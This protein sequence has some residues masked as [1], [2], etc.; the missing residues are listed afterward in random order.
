MSAD[1]GRSASATPQYDFVVLGAGPAGQKA[2]IQAAKEGQR[3]LLVDRAASAGGECV[4]RG[5]IPSKT[6]RESALR[7][8]DRLGSASGAVSGIPG[9]GPLGLL[10]PRAPVEPLMQRLHAVLTAHES[11]IGRQLDRNG[12]E[13]RRGRARF[14][15]PHTIEITSV[16]GTRRD[17]RGRFVVVA[18]GSRP[19][20]PPEIEVDHEHVLDSD[21]ILSLIYLPCSLIVLG[22]GVIACEFATIFQALGVQV[23]LVDRAERPLAFLDREL[24]DLFVR[25]F[26]RMGGR[27]VAATAAASA[28]H[29]GIANVHVS[30]AGGGML[31]AEKVLVALGRTASIADLGLATAGLGPNARGFL[32]VDAN[33]RTAVPHVYAAGDVIGPPALAASSMEQGRRAV[34]HALGLELGPPHDT[35]PSGIYTIPELASVGIGEAEAQ[36]RGLAIVVGRARFEELARGQING[37]T[38]GLLKLVCDARGERLLGAQILG[39]GAT[40]LIHLAQMAMVGELPVS[41]FVE[42][43]FNFPT[44]AEAYRVAALDVA[45]Q[46][47]K[48]R[49]TG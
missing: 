8:R 16:D 22:A 12:I 23:T 10:G 28:R 26:E 15:D 42:N 47:V 48:L 3:V 11:Y 25:Q 5:T 24:T 43:V 27:F 4:R 36:R 31:T 44:L 33:C 9:A 49:A 17:V 39:E 37:E 29:D 2:A 41:T 1:P 6:L 13:R 45:G 34:R 19:R 35:I 7:L 40:E 32:D 21:S 14:V 46:L 20:T 38:E 18:T 30:I